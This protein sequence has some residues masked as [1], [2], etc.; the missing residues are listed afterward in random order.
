MGVL[1]FI[2]TESDPGLNN[3]LRLTMSGSQKWFFMFIV[4]FVPPQTQFPR[5]RHLYIGQNLHQENCNSQ[6]RQQKTNI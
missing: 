3:V 1:Y 2:Q 6:I 5:S 4:K